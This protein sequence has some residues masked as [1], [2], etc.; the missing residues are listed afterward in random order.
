MNGHLFLLALGSFVRPLPVNQYYIQGMFT[1]YEYLRTINNLQ[2][3]A[4][5]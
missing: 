1:L 4:K 3:V 2:N 5:S